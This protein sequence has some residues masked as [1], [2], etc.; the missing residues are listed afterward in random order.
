MS[1]GQSGESREMVFEELL[2]VWR[3]CESRLIGEFSGDFDADEAEADKDT[4]AWRR[5][6]QEAQS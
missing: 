6:Y 5:R 1:L 3:S 4:E 2:A